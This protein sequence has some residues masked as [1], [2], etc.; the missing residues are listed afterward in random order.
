M[1]K[2]LQ[3][4]Y[5]EKKIIVRANKKGWMNQELM[6]EWVRKVWIPHIKKDRSYLMIWDS[7]S[8]HKNQELIDSLNEDNDTT[9]AL[10]PGG[11]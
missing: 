7:F 1:P 2:K 5:D 4:A 8:C 10:I 3:N 9:V 6:K 11:C